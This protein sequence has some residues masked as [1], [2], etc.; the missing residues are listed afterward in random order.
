LPCET[1]AI[2]VEHPTLSP[3]DVQVMAGKGCRRE[4]YNIAAGPQKRQGQESQDTG[5]N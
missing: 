3:E 2:P 4:I 1:P 5:K